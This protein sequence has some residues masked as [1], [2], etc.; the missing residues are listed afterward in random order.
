[1][2]WRRPA[3]AVVCGS[4]EEASSNSDFGLLTSNKPDHSIKIQ[5]LTQQLFY[6]L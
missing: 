2:P 6:F 5:E 4:A 3:L 1:M